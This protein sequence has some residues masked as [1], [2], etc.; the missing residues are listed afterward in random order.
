MNSSSIAVE[1][2]WPR[3]VSKNPRISVFSG[4]TPII[5]ATPR[6]NLSPSE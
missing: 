5:E 3:Y 4:P 6:Q 2:G 1:T